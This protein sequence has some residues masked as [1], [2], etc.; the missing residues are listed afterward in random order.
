MEMYYVIAFLSTIAFIS[1]L[2]FKVEK[3]ENDV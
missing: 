2:F 3:G 1:S